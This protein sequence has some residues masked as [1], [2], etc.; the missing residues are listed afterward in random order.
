MSGITSIHDTFIRAILADK[1]IALDY[2]KTSL[3]AF[4]KEKLDFTTLTQLPDTY[5]S[6]ELKKTVSDIVYSCRR[7]DGKGQVKV[8]L[9]IEHKSSPYKYTP[10]QIG[11]YIFSGLLRQIGNKEQPSLIIPVLLYH[12]KKKWKYRTMADVF[13]AVDLDL[14]QY[15]P[16]Y[17]YIYHNLGEISD[18]ELEGLN[19][20]FLAA[21]FLALKYSFLKSELKK[22]IPRILALSLGSEAVNPNLQSNLLVY[23][24]G[25]SNLRE[26]QS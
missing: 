19:N 16:H 6:E 4:V 10:I 9:L 8:S 15:V 26:W 5:V 18:E 2:F 12:G 23:P 3:P 24:F 25:I 14:R 13:A 11:S 22:W 7:N 20:K 1:S 21:S 17:E